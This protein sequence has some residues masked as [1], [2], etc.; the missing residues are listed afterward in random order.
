[1]KLGPGNEIKASS[2]APSFVHICSHQMFVEPNIY[3]EVLS[4]VFCT[5]KGGLMGLVGGGGVAKAGR[6][7]SSPH[8]SPIV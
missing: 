5:G 4:G 1:M 3:R 6:G 2:K 7:F 8:G